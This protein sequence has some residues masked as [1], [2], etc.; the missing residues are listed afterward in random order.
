MDCNYNLG[1]VSCF[2]G[3]SEYDVATNILSGQIEFSL[4]SHLFG[5]ATAA[6]GLEA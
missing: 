6:D 5:G 3:Y 2:V 4:A 1:Y